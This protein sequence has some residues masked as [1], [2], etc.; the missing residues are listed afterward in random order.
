M[1]ECL[2]NWLLMLVFEQHF[3]QSDGKTLSD[4]ADI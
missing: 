4:T 2:C 1:E 3:V